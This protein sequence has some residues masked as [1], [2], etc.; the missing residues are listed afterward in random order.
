MDRFGGSE[1][2][3]AVPLP[4]P[5]NSFESAELVFE[6][7]AANPLTLIHDR[8]SIEKESIANYL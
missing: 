7:F 6:V 2:E 8:R 5:M 3:S 1:L 4:Y